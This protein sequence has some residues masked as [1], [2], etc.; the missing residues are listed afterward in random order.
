MEMTRATF[1]RRRSDTIEASASYMFDLAVVCT[2]SEAVLGL[3]STLLCRQ[4]PKMRFWFGL[5]RAEKQ[6]LAGIIR[7]VI[8]EIAA[9]LTAH[10]ALM[11][12]R[13]TAV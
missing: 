7:S 13:P 3:K 1:I 8:C 4:P 11:L 10:F 6:T 9:L 5:T 2:Q 12:W